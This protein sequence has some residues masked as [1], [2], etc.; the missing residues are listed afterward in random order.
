MLKALRR[1]PGFYKRLISL[2]APMVLQNLI[3]NSLGFVDTFMVGLVGSN[4]LSAVTA[5]NT[6]IFLL[7]CAIFGMMSG[8]SVLVTQYW[9]QQDMR[10]IN[11]C[12]G[13]V[14][15]IAL[16]VS[17]LAAGLLFFFPTQIMS[18]VTNNPLLIELGAP[19]LQ[20]VGLGYVFNSVSSDLSIKG[21]NISDAFF[22]TPEWERRQT[23]GWKK[24]CR[25]PIAAD[26]AEVSDGQ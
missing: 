18:F 21:H 16:G 19:Y 12:L 7:Q 13:V 26:T 10:A 3:T 8:L 17:S 15:Y 1:E 6:P 25:L 20:L 23:C 9:G 4:E 14:L 11:K 2:A 22:R 24:I 5:A